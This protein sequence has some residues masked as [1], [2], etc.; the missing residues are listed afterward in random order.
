MYRMEKVKLPHEV[1]KAIEKLRSM[2]FKITNRDIITAF[3]NHIH[4]GYP[5]L[6]DYAESNFNDL[7]LALVNGY[8]VEDSP[9]DK[10]IVLYNRFFNSGA[11][12]KDEAYASGAIAGIKLTL[13]ALG[14]NI[15]G[16]NS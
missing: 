6:V 3:C 8:D 16:V 2:D 10:V 15:K 11:N 5:A 1:A 13:E 4:D 12:E 14:K 7:L 9:E